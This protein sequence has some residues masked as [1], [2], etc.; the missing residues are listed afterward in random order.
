M[1]CCVI[2]F[3][4]SPEDLLKASQSSF[5]R[6]AEE[7][8]LFSLPFPCYH[9][10]TVIISSLNPLTKFFFNMSSKRWI[11]S[12]PS[13][14]LSSPYRFYSDYLLLSVACF[15][16]HLSNLVGTVFTKKLALKLLFKIYHRSPD[17][18][19]NYH[20]LSHRQG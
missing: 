3:L 15:A 7:T 6:T 2:C 10:H 11:F 9:G 20:T 8:C 17:V 5:P 12:T 14:H 1:S 4:K 19:K 13:L 18:T 16:I